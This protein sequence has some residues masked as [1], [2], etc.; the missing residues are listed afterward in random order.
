MREYLENKSDIVE[1]VAPGIR[2]E[3][4]TT[5]ADSRHA[6]EHL[7]FRPLVLAR[8]HPIGSKSQLLNDGLISQYERF[9]QN[10]SYQVSLEPIDRLSFVYYLLLQNRIDE[11]LD[12]FAGIARE[13]LES[14][15]QYDYMDMYLA[16]FKL[17]LDRAVVIA[18]RYRDY[19]HPRWNSLFQEAGNQIA[20][21]RAMESGKRIANDP[22][23]DWTDASDQRLL[24]GERERQNA[25]LAAS[26]PLLDMIANEQ[27]IVIR[28]RE[29]SGIRVNF[30]WMDIELQFSRAPFVTK[31]SSRLS[32]IEANRSEWIALPKSSEIETYRF[33]LPDEMRNR[34]VLV[35]VSAAGLTSSTMI[36]SNSLRVNLAPNAG[37][38][39]VI[40]LDRAMPLEATY[41]KVYR[42]S[43]D[44][45]VA[46]YKDGY[47]DIR[48]QFDYTSLSLDELGSIER[49]A[50]LV[51]HPKHG[52]S[53]HEVLPPRR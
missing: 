35:E 6:Y 7:D 32:L 42:R 43:S 24:G 49:F 31:D 11:A 5:D 20:E 30:Y 23:I 13:S 22:S 18:D 40:G 21:R 1:A 15:L 25:L 46:F 2:S 3:I 28:Y 12:V 38:L 52:A 10:A 44:G 26:E 34:N 41:I 36:Y 50:I 8:A 17:D 29:L 27:E 37:R 47:T 39:Q 19:P 4:L 16:F 45:K 14:K 48:G 33:A 9:L 53:V 51:L